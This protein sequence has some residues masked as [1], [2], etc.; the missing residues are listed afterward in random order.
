MHP[1]HKTRD[2]AGES[3]NDAALHR[4]SFVAP[5]DRSFQSEPCFTQFMRMWRLVE[6]FLPSA[7]TSLSPS[8]WNRTTATGPTTLTLV[9]SYFSE[10]IFDFP[11]VALAMKAALSSTR[12]SE[13]L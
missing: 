11:L 2:D 4:Q 13:W 3:G 7:T 5:R 9:S 12:P 1:G 10:R 8:Q 6:F